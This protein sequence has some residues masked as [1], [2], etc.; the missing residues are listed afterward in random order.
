V[1]DRGMMGDATHEETKQCREES[2]HEDILTRYY[3]TKLRDKKSVILLTL[4]R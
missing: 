4:R 2:R 3:V 1:D